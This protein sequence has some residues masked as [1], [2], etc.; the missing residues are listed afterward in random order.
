MENILWAFLWFAVLGGVLG[1]LLA[2]AGKLFEVKVDERIP[3]IMELLP[4]AN[5]GGCG[6]SG[7]AAFAEAVVKGE[8]APG[9]CRANK[10]K[11]TAALN[12]LMGVTPQHKVVRMRAQVMCSGTA[13][14]T[15]TQYLY[16]GI[17]DCYAAAKLGGG[18]KCCPNGC[19]GLGTCV[20]TCKF[21]AIHIKDGIAQVDYEKCRA[22]GMCVNACPQHIIRLIPFGA[23]L[24]VGCVS[25]EKGALTR[26]YCEVGCIGCKL[27]EKACATGAIKV[28]DF[29][30]TIDYSLCTHCGA[31]A[32][33]CPRKIIHIYKPDES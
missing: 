25:A 14:R 21:D 32:E 16:N 22:C 6:K 24:W 17:H 33:K 4:G 1:V 15:K 5:C 2:I 3:Q 8:L 9:A 20:A 26:S 28:T 13:D 30:A 11:N 31:C 23:K 10:K 27:C 18:D 29:H 7:C 19:I 12:A